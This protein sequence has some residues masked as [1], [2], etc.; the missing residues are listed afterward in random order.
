MDHLTLGLALKEIRFKT[1][2]KIQK[3]HHTHTA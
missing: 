2:A 1:L 3:G